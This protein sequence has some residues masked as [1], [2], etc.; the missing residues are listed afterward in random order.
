MCVNM[1]VCATN[2]PTDS[3]GQVLEIQLHLKLIFVILI[4]AVKIFVVSIQAVKIFVV[5]IRAEKIS[6]QDSQ[7][8]KCHLDL[9]VKSFLKGGEWIIFTESYSLKYIFVGI[10][11]WYF[12]FSSSWYLWFCDFVICGCTWVWIW[13]LGLDCAV[14]C[15]RGCSWAPIEGNT[16][17]YEHQH[18]DQ[19]PQETGDFSSSLATSLSRQGLP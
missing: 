5:S 14:G 10:E 13:S 4:Q 18:D 8:L 3:Q 11:I 17:N 2:Q 1:K 12:S 19:Q 16:R 6:P 7:Y 9:K 15:W